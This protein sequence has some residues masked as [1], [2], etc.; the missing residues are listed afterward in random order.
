MEKENKRIESALPK[1]VKEVLG[2][3]SEYG[4]SAYLHGECV[5]VLIKGQTHLDEVKAFDFDLFTNATMPRIR[6][7]FENYQVNEENLERGE[8]IV[9]ILGVAVS[10]TCYTDLESELKNEHAFTFDAIA[11]TPVKGVLDL[12]GGLSDLEKGE[13]N[14]IET[15]K[16]F[17]PHDILPALAWQSSGEFNISDLAKEAILNENNI[18]EMAKPSYVK[19]SQDAKNLKA[20]LTE[21]NVATVLS[22]YSKVFIAIIP[23]LKKLYS[24]VLDNIAA[25]TFKCV[26]SSAP[27]LTL[28]YALLFHELGKEDCRAVN[29][30]GE[31]SFYGHAERA[32]IYAK[33][34]MS[35]L[36]CP[37]EDIEETEYIIE[38]AQKASCADEE[39][40]ADLKD[41]FPPHL[42][43]LLLLFNCAICRGAE[44]PDEK[45]AGKFKKLSK[46]LR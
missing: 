35:R 28:R 42:L 18:I 37:V 45:S 25:H 44:T 30:N 31:E 41:E 38:N 6:A 11:Y 5:R 19:E 1:Q 14:F 15:G 12:F 34:I 29:A 17:N 7:I 24:P 23:E 27:I 26:G 36:G 39:N 43:K 9:T 46:G 33:R 40:I 10:I 16:N 4:Y 21:R 13:L 8:L 20:I 2:K 22:E 3:L 32:R